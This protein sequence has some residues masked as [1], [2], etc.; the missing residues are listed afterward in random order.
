MAIRDAGGGPE[1]ACNGTFQQ[2][3]KW[4][5]PRPWRFTLDAAE[6]I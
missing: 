5:I 6:E 3:R 4:L 1:F 2:R